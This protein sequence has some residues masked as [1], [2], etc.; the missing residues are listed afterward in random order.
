MEEPQ[1]EYPSREV[2]WT[3][4]IVWIVIGGLLLPLV[5]QYILDILAGRLMET[6]SKQKT[7]IDVGLKAYP[8][9]V[10]IPCA[11]VTSKLIT[12]ARYQKTG[13]DI[14]KATIISA[15]VGLL[16]SV[17][18][19]VFIKFIDFLQLTILA[20]AYFGGIYGLIILPLFAF[21]ISALIGFITAL[22]VL[23]AKDY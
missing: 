14:F 22:I 23:P 21:F 2:L 19:V 16:F 3:F 9:F 8:L 18:P 6:L 5:I 7:G 4:A 15:C 11:F 17:A 10:S 12:N 1:N 20:F 13:A